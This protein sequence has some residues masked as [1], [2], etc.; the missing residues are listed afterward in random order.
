ML[1]PMADQHAERQIPWLPDERF[2]LALHARQGVLTN[3]AGGPD[4][5]TLT[6]LRAIRRGGRSGRHTTSVIS[7]SALSGVEVV[8]FARAPER[9]TQGLVVLGIGLVVAWISWIIFATALITLVLGGVPILV[10]VYLLAGYAFP[11]DDGELILHSPGLSIR[12]PLL[13]PDARGDAYLVAHRVFELAAAM[14]RP[15]PAPSSTAEVTQAAPMNEPAAPT[16]SPPADATQAPPTARE[17][18]P[19]SWVYRAHG[20]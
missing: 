7:L 8:D 9:L 20:D 4:V 17:P 3:P 5:L 1:T 11:D 15:P 19:E 13:T 2:E 6:T 18:S 12:Q 16:P 14:S 10:G